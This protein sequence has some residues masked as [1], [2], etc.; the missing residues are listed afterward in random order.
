MP[1]YEGPIIDAHHHFWEPELSRQPWLLPDAN[2]PFRYG[3]Y[4]AIKC[5]YLP[6]DLLRDAAGFNIVGSVTMETEWDLD[7]PVGEMVYTTLRK[8]GSPLIRYRSRDL[9]RLIPG[10]RWVVTFDADGQH[11]LDDVAHLLQVA[12]ETGVDV[13]MGSR[14]LG[15][16]PVAMPPV[17]RAVLRAAITFSNALTGL[18]LTDTHNG[19]RVLSRRLANEL[20]ITM[21]DMAHA[22]EIIEI[23]ATKGY[24]YQEAP[25]TIA[26]G[27]PWRCS[28]FSRRS[29]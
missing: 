25:V 29:T 12:E 27:R 13:V 5:S 9:T 10:L 11:Q 4:N 20:Q 24:T 23:V 19:L 2:I 8:E 1:A 15:A 22:S 28:A 6:P 3:D 26:S 16:E 18:R 17:K 7:D 21:P 14:F